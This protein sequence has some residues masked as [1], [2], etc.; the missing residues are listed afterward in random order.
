MASVPSTL[1]TRFY[2]IGTP[3]TIFWSSRSSR[4]ASALLPQY[5]K[6]F[7][8]RDHGGDACRVIGRRLPIDQVVERVHGPSQ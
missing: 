8:G 5:A 3:L 6:R 2:N 1:A 4:T 7:I